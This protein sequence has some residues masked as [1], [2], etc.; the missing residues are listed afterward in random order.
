MYCSTSEIIGSEDNLLIFRS[1]SSDKE[2]CCIDSMLTSVEMLYLL[3]VGLGPKQIFSTSS[4][5][6]CTFERSVSMESMEG[7]LYIDRQLLSGDEALAISSA[8]SLAC[9]LS[10]SKS[11]LLILSSRNGLVT[12]FEGDLIGETPIVHLLTWLVKLFSFNID[13]GNV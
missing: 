5:L 12:S 3:Q 7:E 4:K 2:S 1:H 11:E 9:W 6:T 8:T 10:D 13:G